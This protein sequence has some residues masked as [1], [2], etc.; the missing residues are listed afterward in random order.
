MPSELG[1][2]I[3]GAGFMGTAHARAARLAGARLVGVAVSTPDRAKEAAARLGADRAFP[4]PEVLVT[5]PEVDVVHLCVPNQLHAPLATIALAHG[6]HVVCEKPLTLD[7]GS[8]D[9]LV[10]AQRAAGTIGAVPFVYRFHPMVRELRARIGAADLGALHLVHGT[11]LQDWLAG[12]DGDDWRL[13]PILGGRSRAFAD[14]GSHWFDL[15]EFVTGTQVVRLS[16][17]FT[18]MFDTRA[19]EDTAVVQFE[20]NGGAIGSVVVSQVAAGRKNALAVEC[21]GTG[22]S[23]RFDGEAPGALWLGQRDRAVVVSADP[24][25]LAPDA[26]RHVVVP[27]GHP[28]GYLDC[29]DRFVVDAYAAI[30]GESPEGLPT[31][32]DGRRSVHLIDAALRSA[33]TNGAWI[34]VAR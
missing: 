22:G 28:Q 13:D 16:A 30:A 33:G 7:G 29:I 8:A 17:R 4:S 31:F 23:A 5:D 32:E 14:I 3:V 25:T 34:E 27:P 21:S 9:A 11:Y 12:A 26:A 10:D 19:N 6:K 18:Q 2:G 24:H 20:L 1:A 15:V